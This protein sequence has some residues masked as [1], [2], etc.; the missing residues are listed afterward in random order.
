VDECLLVVTC[1]GSA[2]GAIRCLPMSRARSRSMDHQ[3]PDTEAVLRGRERL[4][5]ETRNGEDQIC[6]SAAST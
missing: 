5:A 1:C 3:S 2:R 6:T 4:V